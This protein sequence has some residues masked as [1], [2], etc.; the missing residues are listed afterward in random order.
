MRTILILWAVC[1]PAYLAAQIGGQHV[2]EF[3]NLSPSAR[4]V[5]LGGVNISTMDDDVNFGVQNPALVSDS[6]H[7]R[8][9]LSFSSYLAGIKYGYAGY[10]HT[11]EGIGSFHSGIQYI[12]SGSMRGADEF[13]NLT[14]EFSASEL[15]WYLGISRA[16]RQFRYGA[17]LKFISSTLGPGYSSVGMALDLG[18]SYQ[19]KSKLFSAGMVIRNIGTQFTTYTGAPRE[20]LPFEVLL[21]VSNKLKYMPL[22]FSITLTNLEQPRLIF[23]DPDAPVELDLSGNPIEPRNQTADQIFRHGVFSAEFLLGKSLRLRAGYNHLRRQELR[24][25]NRAGMTGFSMGIGIRASR[26][27][28]DYGFSSFGLNGRLFAHQFSLL[29]RLGN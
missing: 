22:R 10:S 16:W 18:G 13:G 23:I 9:S 6:M 17:N 29:Y 8:M 11:F 27:A 2:Y 26:F 25:E 21:G 28:F 4:I 3:L 1:L 24:S 20:G 15:A 7:Q 19:S 14:G 12:N 5:S